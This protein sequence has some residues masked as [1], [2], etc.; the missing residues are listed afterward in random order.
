MKAQI[1]KYID[2]KSKLYLVCY[3]WGLC[4]SFETT[5][6]R[7]VCAN[8]ETNA[9]PERFVS[10]MDEDDGGISTNTYIESLVVA[11]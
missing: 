9:R 4:N 3:A 5:L 1:R 7:S 2:P 8:D 6:K 11:E 10:S